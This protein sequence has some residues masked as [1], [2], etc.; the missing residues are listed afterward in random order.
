MFAVFKYSRQIHLIHDGTITNELAGAKKLSWRLISTQVLSELLK[1]GGLV[2]DA[3]QSISLCGCYLKAAQETD[4]DDFTWDSCVFL[5]PPFPLLPARPKLPAPVKN[6]V[7]GWTHLSPDPVQH[8]LCSCKD[9]K[10]SLGAGCLAERWESEFWERLNEKWQP[11]PADQYGQGTGRTVWPEG[12]TSPQ[13]TVKASLV[14][15]NAVIYVHL[16]VMQQLNS[17]RMFKK[18][19]R[20]RKLTHKLSLHYMNNSEV[21]YA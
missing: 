1:T 18:K 21:L 7:L 15:C 10:P 3:E 20:L 12:W 8:F 2:Q 19:I 13:K 6:T 16:L 11:F 17:S 4:P 9:K 5:Q 14:W